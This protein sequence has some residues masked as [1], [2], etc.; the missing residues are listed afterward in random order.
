M[1]TK[2]QLE[3]IVRSK[4]IFCDNVNGGANKE[5]FIIGMMSGED[6]QTYT[7]SPSHAK[8]F[9]IWIAGIVQNYEKEF[10]E[11]DTNSPKPIVSPIQ[12]TDVNPGKKK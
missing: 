11:I 8:R 5:N 4:K 7:F 10:G 6:I 9:S 12:P 1:D 2:Q 3:T